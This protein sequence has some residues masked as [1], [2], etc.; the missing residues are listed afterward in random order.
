MFYSNSYFFFKKKLQTYDNV[1]V[2][3]VVFP[4]LFFFFVE[5][6]QANDLLL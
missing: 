1:C 4:Y 5:L 6:T 2:F 3:F